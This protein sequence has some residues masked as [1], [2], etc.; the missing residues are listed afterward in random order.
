MADGEADQLALRV[1]LDPTPP[2]WARAE[3]EGRGVERLA[4][5]PQLP[6]EFAGLNEL[7]T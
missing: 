1:V 4:A 5:Y 3:F 7:A 2:G 6:S